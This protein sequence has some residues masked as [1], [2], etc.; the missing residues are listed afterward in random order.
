[1]EV[2]LLEEV[3]ERKWR[4][5]YVARPVLEAL[6]PHR[7]VEEGA[8]TPEELLDEIEKQQATIAEAIN[9]LRRL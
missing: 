4:R 6:N 8:R 9:E 2:E 3:G 7:V 1:V 5:L